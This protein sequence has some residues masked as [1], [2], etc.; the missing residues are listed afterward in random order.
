M[1]PAGALLVVVALLVGGCSDDGNK[2]EG[3]AFPDN[4]PIVDDGECR[5][6]ATDPA[7]PAIPVTGEPTDGVEVRSVK[8]EA[9]GTDHV[10]VTFAVSHPPA[11]SAGSGRQWLVVQLHGVRKLPPDGAVSIQSPRARRL[12]ATICDDSAW[13]FALAFDARVVDVEL[14]PASPGEIEL[15]VA[16]A[17]S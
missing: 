7:R 1:R 16:L 6:P 9:G 8:V 15:D 12:E 14:V 3:S 5:E 13:V 2:K 11:V 17:G 4:V 10:G